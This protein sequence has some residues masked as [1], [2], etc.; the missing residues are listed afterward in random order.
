[1]APPKA[2]LF[3]IGGVVAI[4][5]YETQN[6][7]PS[8]WIN[9]AISQSKPDG[10]WHRL[11]RGEFE[12]NE[13]FSRGFSGDLHNARVWEE[14]QKRHRGGKKKLKDI[15][16]PSQLADPVSLKAVT[17]DSEPTHQDQSSQYSINGDQNA[18]PAGSSMKVKKNLKDLATGNPTRLGDLVSLKAEAS[19]SELTEQDRGARSPTPQR[20]SHSPYSSSTPPKHPKNFAQAIPSHFGDPVSLK[21]ETANSSPT[22]PP[23]P[24]ICQWTRP[25]RPRHPS[26]PPHQPLPFPKS[27]PRTSSGT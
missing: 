7:I 6:D 15:A 10:F 27:T 1:M 19:D 9:F 12:V 2:L 26:S 18:S 13:D 16:N 22:P 17:A 21:A 25:P 3:D 8:G 24:L 4:V 23:K 11:E 20:T 5:N 14:F